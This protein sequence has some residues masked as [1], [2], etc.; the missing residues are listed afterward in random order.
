MSANAARHA[1]EVHL[2][3]RIATNDGSVIVTLAS[4][5][6]LQLREYSAQPTREPRHGI[7]MSPHPIPLLR[8][9]LERAELEAITRGLITADDYVRAGLDLPP[10]LR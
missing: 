3:G 7:T 6:Q 10:Q 4:D 9:A 1:A 2:V 8:A 5:G